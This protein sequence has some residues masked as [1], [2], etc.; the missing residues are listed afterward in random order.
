V[1]DAADSAPGSTASAAPAGASLPLEG[2][3]VIEIG[4]AVCAPLC[5]RHLCDLGAEVI[6]VER[7]GVGDLARGYDSVVWGTSAYFTWANYGKKSVVLDLASAGGVDA[8]LDL[9][10]TADVI[11]HNL[12]PGAMDRLGLS[13][14]ALM[15]RNPR[16]IACEISG[17]GAAGPYKEKKAFDM[18]VQGEVGLISLT[19]TQETPSKVGISVVDM[20]AAVYALSSIQAA[21]LLRARTGAGSALEISLLDSI[22]EWMMAPA[23]HQLYAGRAPKR[24]GARHNMMVPYGLYKTGP[25][26]AVNFAVQTAAQWQNLCERVLEAPEL[27]NDSRFAGNADRLRNRVTL[28]PMIEGLL[29]KIGH[30]EVISRLEASQ[31]PVARVNDLAGFVDHPQ[32]SAR[33]RW[34]EIDVDGNATRALRPPFNLSDEAPRDKRVPGLGEHTN[35]IL[36]QLPKRSQAGRLAALPPAGCRPRPPPPSRLLIRAGA[37]WDN[38]RHGPGTGV[39]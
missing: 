30:D 31:I 9:V 34:F 27:V 6:K 24:E 26:T 8:L 38:G 37:A 23:Y 33:N 16:L 3:R 7:P 20:C 17:Y 32:L 11:V 5:A 21:L 39:A 35:E 29:M 10:E 25:Q 14:E 1:H 36:G 2:L 22:G 18:L 13:A 19:G 12:G 4:Q 15:A 28:E